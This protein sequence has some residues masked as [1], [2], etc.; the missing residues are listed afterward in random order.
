MLA[1]SASDRAYSCSI[2]ASALAIWRSPYQTIATASTPA[3]MVL[4]MNP[5]VMNHAGSAP[6]SRGTVNS[7][8]DDQ[9]YA[10][11]SRCDGQPDALDADHHD[12]CYGCD[13]KV[14]LNTDAGA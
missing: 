1:S 4:T 5:T 3:A 11:G 10:D 12:S 8:C 2:A 9:A 13:Q 7:Q 14:E 6:V